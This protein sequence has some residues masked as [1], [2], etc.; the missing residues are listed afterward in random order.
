MI[1]I[2]GN[3]S[4]LSHSDISYTP[5]ISPLQ[6]HI[7]ETMITHPEVAV[8]RNLN[9]LR[10]DLAMRESIIQSAYALNQS[11]ASFAVFSRAYCNPMYWIRTSNG[12]FQLRPDR[13]PSDA[14]RNIFQQGDLYGFECATAIIIVFYHAVLQI[15]GDQ[16]F[17]ELFQGLYIRDWQHDQDLHVI[18]RKYRMYIPGDVRYFKN[19]DHDPMRPEWQGE[20]VVDVGYGLYYGHGIGI[21]SGAEIIAFLNGLRYPMAQR[22]AYLLDQ[23][24]RIRSSQLYPY[25]SHDGRALDTLY[26][27]SV[28]YASARIGSSLMLA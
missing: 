13:R 28:H 2:Y 3:P 4:P 15:L 8:Y 22:S 5:G 12:G 26:R 6:R 19:P 27:E 24:T 21:R 23:A 1:K 9:E 20:N 10:F 17:N 7:L 16:T 14:I 11:G 25:Y 18:T